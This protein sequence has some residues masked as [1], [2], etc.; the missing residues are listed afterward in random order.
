MNK[1][2]SFVAVMVVLLSACTTNEEPELKEIKNLKFDVLES[3]LTGEVVVYNPNSIGATL[4]MVDLEIFV[5]ND[6]VG[7]I[8]EVKEV[9]VG[10][11]KESTVPFQAKIEVNTI[12]SIIKDH[13]LAIVFGQKLE[14]RTRGQIM[15]KA[16]ARNH[17]VDVDFLEEID[18]REIAR[19]LLK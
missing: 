11:K 1:L 14:V 2:L 18:F 19:R 7:R 17:V 3:L 5:A 9:R 15:A 13:G 6:N 12:K 10:A 4:K 16:G 8:Q